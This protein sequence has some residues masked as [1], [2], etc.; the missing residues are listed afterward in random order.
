MDGKFCESS[1][2]TTHIAE[3][4]W[5]HYPVDDKTR[6]E[7]RVSELLDLVGISPDRKTQY[8]HQFSGGMRQR[9]MIA[10]NNFV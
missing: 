5:R 6:V 3:A 8:P 9:V 1:L 10:R 7:A 2:T 4:I